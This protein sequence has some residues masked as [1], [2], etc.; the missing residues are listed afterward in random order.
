MFVYAGTALALLMLTSLYERPILEVITDEQV[1]EELVRTLASAIGLVLAVPIT[2]A[3]A[4]ATVRP[5][6]GEEDDGGR[7]G[8]RRAGRDASDP[9]RG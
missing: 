9:A 3:I 7:R 5:R 1:A 6:R 8:A 2:T 4:A